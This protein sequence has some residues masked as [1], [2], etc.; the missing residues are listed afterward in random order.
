MENYMTIDEA[1]NL[2]GESVF[3]DETDICEVTESFPIKDRES[4]SARRKKTYFKGKK[5]YDRVYQKGFT[6]F[7]NKESVVRGMMRKT[8]VVR[9]YCSSDNTR[10]KG[11]NHSIIRSLNSVDNKM[12]DYCKE[13]V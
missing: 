8:N 4:K 3:G 1:I 13:A 10:Q 11:F 6:P 12:S 2:Y 5:R 9:V 7:P